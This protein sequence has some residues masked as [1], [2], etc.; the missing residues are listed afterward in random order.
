MNAEYQ[1][2][3]SKFL[4]GKYATGAIISD[5]KYQREKADLFV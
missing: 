3:Q 1:M 4:R 5:A 2:A